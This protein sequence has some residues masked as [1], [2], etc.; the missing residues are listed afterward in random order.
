MVFTQGDNDLCG[1]LGNL[2]G[3]LLGFWFLGLF[4]TFVYYVYLPLSARKSLQSISVLSNDH[5]S[6][7]AL[8]CADLYLGVLNS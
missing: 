4:K 8:V 3:I 1:R 6:S 5:R 7:V 2:F